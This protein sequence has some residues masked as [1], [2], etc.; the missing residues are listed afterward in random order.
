MNHVVLTSR[1]PALDSVHFPILIEKYEPALDSKQGLCLTLEL[2]YM[3]S[4]WN[5]EAAR[6]SPVSDLD[7]RHLLWTL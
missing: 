6:L 7:Y 1:K 5:I 2:T 3:C 4:H